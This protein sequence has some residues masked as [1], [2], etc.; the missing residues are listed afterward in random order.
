MWTVTSGGDN[1]AVNEVQSERS[2]SKTTLTVRSANS[3]L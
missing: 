2:P 1:A 3:A